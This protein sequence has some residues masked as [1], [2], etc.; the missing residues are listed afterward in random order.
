MG[1]THA[2]TSAKEDGAD[3]TLV[4]PG[5]WNAD[6]VGGLSASLLATAGDMLYRSSAI[7]Y[8]TAA[9]G[10]S[11]SCPNGG[12]IGV[13]GN[14]IDGDDATY[15]GTFNFASSP[16]VIDLGVARTISTWRVK[17]GYSYSMTSFKWQYSTNGTDYS[18]ATGSITPN[19]GNPFTNT[20]SLNSAIEARYWKFLPVDDNYSV[21][22]Y[23]LE[24]KAAESATTLAIGSTG[25]VLTVASGAPAWAA[26]KAAFSGA[27]VFNSA[28]QS[29][30]DT[31]ITAL[32][33]DSESYDTDAI[34]AGGNP[35]RMTA[36]ATGYW[37][38]T[39]G[40]AWDANSANLRYLW[41]RIDG[42]TEVN[43]GMVTGSPA[44]T[45]LAQMTSVTLYLTS[46]QWVELMAYQ[47]S[48][49]ARNIGGTSADKKF[50]TWLEAHY[51]GA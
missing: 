3:D 42:T 37:R 30:P 24:L 14:I 49:G 6:H 39:G 27:R 20:G 47:T 25:E 17:V 7:N 12:N 19:G 44:A 15:F 43:G 33:F 29:I 40:G 22:F 38:L 1:I 4:Q 13:V 26:P 46:G 51:L 31:E 45:S 2:F 23:T 28:T 41:W 35:T 32:T 5:D 11:A 16:C 8:A 36:H 9:Y 21:S 10:A 50:E 48:G 18:D 34:H